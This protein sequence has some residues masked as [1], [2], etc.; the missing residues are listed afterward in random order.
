VKYVDPDGL[1]TTIY[2]HSGEN[3]WGH[4]AINVNGTVYSFGRYGEIWGSSYRPSSPSGEGILFAV[5]EKTYFNDSFF[6]AHTSNIQEYDL[7]LTAKQEAGI[8]G[9]FKN[10]ID[11]GTSV[12]IKDSNGISRNAFKLENDYNLF[13]NN[14]TTLTLDSLPNNIR[15]AIGNYVSPFGL[16]LGLSKWDL[17]TDWTASLGLGSDWVETGEYHEMS[18]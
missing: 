11:N 16:G 8:V 7:K 6:G 2:I 18:E 12:S 17:W 14:C 5:S 1:R 13:T 9:F 3:L 4:T 15:G 10:Q